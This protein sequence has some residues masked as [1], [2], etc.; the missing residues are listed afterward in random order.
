MK[1]MKEKPKKMTAKENEYYFQGHVPREV[2]EKLEACRDRGMTVGTMAR[3]LAYLWL[4]LPPEK[5]NQLYFS[6]IDVDF[7][8]KD[9]GISDLLTAVDEVL[10]G[11]ILALLPQSAKIAESLASVQLT[12]QA[13]QHKQSRRQPKEMSGTG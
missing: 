1:N 13:R 7:D 8:P 5:Q 3:K 10:V 11:K 2:Q 12:K 4:A 6:L 9:K